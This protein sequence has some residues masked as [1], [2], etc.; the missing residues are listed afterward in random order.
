MPSTVFS[1]DFKYHHPMLTPRQQ[2]NEAQG[3]LNSFLQNAPIACDL[4]GIS[5]SD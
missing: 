1:N 3:N 5:S 4:H 2:L